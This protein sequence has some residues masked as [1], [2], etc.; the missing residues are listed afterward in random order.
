[1]IFIIWLKKST[2][3]R[4]ELHLRVESLRKHISPTHEDEKFQNQRRVLRTISRAQDAAKS[5]QVSKIT[6]RDRALRV[7]FRARRQLAARVLRARRRR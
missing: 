4:A 3:T 5:T 7:I 2:K 1:M 6:L